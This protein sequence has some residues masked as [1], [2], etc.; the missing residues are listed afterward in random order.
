MSKSTL[1]RVIDQLRKERDRI[2]KRMESIE[3][4]LAGMEIIP[5]KVVSSPVSMQQE[6]KVSRARRTAASRRL[7]VGE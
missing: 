2:G 6:R 1:S 3:A 4:S 5:R 7:S